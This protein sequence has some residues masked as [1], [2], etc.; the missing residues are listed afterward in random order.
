[1]T[2]A[3]M[4]MRSIYVAVLIKSPLI[5]MTFFN[6][7]Y[8]NVLSAPNIS[9]LF[10]ACRVYLSQRKVGRGGKFFHQPVFI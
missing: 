6:V 1:M 3:V 4:G 2:A 9:Q 10:K 8:K 7:H 5:H